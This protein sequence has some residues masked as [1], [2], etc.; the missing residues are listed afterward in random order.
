MIIPDNFEQRVLSKMM[1]DILLSEF[2]TKPYRQGQQNQ[3]LID[4]LSILKNI[5]I[6][7]LVYLSLKNIYLK[8]LFKKSL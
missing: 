6:I 5:L 3:Q 8:N 1:E 2:I 4:T 7:T